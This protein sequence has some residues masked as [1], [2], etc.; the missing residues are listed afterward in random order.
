MSAISTEYVWQTK[1]S[2]SQICFVFVGSFCADSSEIICNFLQDFF[3]ARI[4]AQ[5]I[6]F[7]QSLNF[8]AWNTLSY[9]S[10]HD[11]NFWLGKCFRNDDT[12]LL[13]EKPLIVETM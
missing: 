7:L 12:H 8:T 13:L 6:N 9:S 3:M 11:S 10:M 4:F 5:E 1:E 2:C